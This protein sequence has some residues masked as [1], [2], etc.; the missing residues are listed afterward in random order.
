MVHRHCHRHP[1]NV[2][3][4]LRSPNLLHLSPYSNLA[5]GV[6]NSSSRKIVMIRIVVNKSQT[7]ALE[8][9]IIRVLSKATVSFLLSSC[10]QA[11]DKRITVPGR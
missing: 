5:A 6:C 4:F 9:R 7:R 11:Q 3:H 10:Q 8:A 2:F 1:F